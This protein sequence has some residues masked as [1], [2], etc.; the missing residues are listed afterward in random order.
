MNRTRND[1]P[2]EKTD[3]RCR[4]IYVTFAVCFEQEKKKKA[5]GGDEDEDDEEEQEEE[6]VAYLSGAD[7]EEF[8]PS[9]LPDPDKV[10]NS[11]DEN[12]DG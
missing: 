8:D 4:S 12:D 6:V 10:R 5:G 3:H 2:H 7:D 1:F 9:T 11:E